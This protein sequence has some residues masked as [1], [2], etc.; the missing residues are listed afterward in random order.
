VD[1]VRSKLIDLSTL[2][3]LKFEDGQPFSIVPS[4]TDPDGKLFCLGAST[5]GL[6]V[7]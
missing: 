4:S 2:G 3:P 7:G 1:E 6:I 5:F